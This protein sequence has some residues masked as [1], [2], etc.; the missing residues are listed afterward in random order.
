MTDY[1]APKLGK[2]SS[3]TH[4]IIK[5]SVI[6]S[7]GRSLPHF[8][9]AQT[10]APPPTNAASV[11]RYRILSHVPFEIYSYKVNIYTVYI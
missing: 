7:V 8:Y 4:T 1:E 6:L 9:G 11:L 2:G 3:G 5:R 10:T